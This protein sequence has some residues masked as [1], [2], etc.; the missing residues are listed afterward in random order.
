M[1]APHVTGAV[2]LM[3]DKNPHLSSDSVKAILRRAAKRYAGNPDRFD[4]W[5]EEAL[6]LIHGLPDEFDP[7]SEPPLPRVFTLH[8]NYPNP[9][10]PATRIEFEVPSESGNEAAPVRVDVY[11]ILGQR[12]A[13]LLDGHLLPGHYILTWDGT[14]DTGDQ[15]TSGMYFYRCLH[16]G[17]VDTKKMVLVK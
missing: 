15:V 11:N 14:T 13:T 17:D 3:F 4:L 10:N 7:S 5:V 6:L 2:A 9:F 16:D 12:I 8:Q 1:A